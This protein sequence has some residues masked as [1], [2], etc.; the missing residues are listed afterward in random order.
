VD[1]LW[2]H[3]GL[4]SRV[5]AAQERLG[6][7]CRWGQ[8]EI[9]LWSNSAHVSAC[10]N[11]FFQIVIVVMTQLQLGFE[12]KVEC[13][14]F[15]EQREG[16]WWWALLQVADPV[17]HIVLSFMWSCRHWRWDLL[18]KNCSVLLHQGL[19]APLNLAI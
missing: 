17:E 5:W 12:W 8:K 11:C 14:F 18:R 19:R 2:I 9:L 10:A 7:A 16:M 3:S 4:S 15:L 13:F 6:A 1:N